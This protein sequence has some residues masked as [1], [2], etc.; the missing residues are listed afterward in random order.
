MNGEEMTTEPWPTTGETLIHMSDVDFYY[1]QGRRDAAILRNFQ[2]EI[3]EREIV[4]LLGPSGCGKTTALRL[5][6]GFEF[7]DGGNVLLRGRPITS[8]GAERGVVFQGDA[9]LYHWL[10]AIDNVAFGLRL[11]GVKRAERHETARRL[12]D[13]TGLSGQHA[14]YPTEL[15]GGMKQRIQIARVL[16]SDPEIMLMDEPF[17]ALDAQTRAELQDEL[18]RIWQR[19]QKTILFITHDIAEAILL[20]TRV[21]VMRRGPNSRIN[22]I[23]DIDLPRPR[24]R[25][26]LEFGQLFERINA[27]IHARPVDERKEARNA[28]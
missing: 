15:S 16:A 5:L 3:R 19:T 13:A 27:L 11:R 8:P 25:D 1:G 26:T 18:V 9:S 23:V 24:R 21:A 2:L 22:E 4:C 10:R 14:K 12:L 28:R 17:G 7:P 6:A 20:G